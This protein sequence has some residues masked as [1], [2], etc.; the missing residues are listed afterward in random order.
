MASIQKSEYDD[1]SRKMEIKIKEIKKLKKEINRL[2]T[3]IDVTA[4]SLD[5]FS[6]ERGLDPLIDH[7]NKSIEK[8]QPIFEHVQT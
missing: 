7:L 1:L 8:Y 3:V 5:S 2:V 6:Y 4:L